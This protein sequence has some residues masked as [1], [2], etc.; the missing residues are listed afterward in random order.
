[1]KYTYKELESLTKYIKTYPDKELKDWVEY[2]SL[3][4][5]EEELKFF[6][7]V[8][9]TTFKMKTDQDKEH[10]FYI[11]RSGIY[12][13][14]QNFTTKFIG[15]KIC[16]SFD[17]SDSYSYRYDILTFD[18]EIWE[19]KNWKDY[20]HYKGVKYI[21]NIELKIN[22]I[23]ENLD[24]GLDELIYESWGRHI[25]NLKY[26]NYSFYNSGTKLLIQ[27]INNFKYKSIDDLFE[28]EK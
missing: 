13:L 8:K 20:K 11:F 4:I 15:N 16:Y 14:L 24:S 2:R 22:I 5:N 17:Q 10:I 1:M 6:K 28:K 26:E 23:W 12:G 7:D 27:D 25:S 18:E 9:Y 21:E 3:F 19:L